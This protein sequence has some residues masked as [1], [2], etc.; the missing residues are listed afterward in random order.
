ASRL[1]AAA[2]ATNFGPRGM[3]LVAIKSTNTT[4]RRSWCMAGGPGTPW[5]L[6]SGRFNSIVV[7]WQSLAHAQDGGCGAWYD[8]FGSLGRAGRTHQRNQGLIVC[9]ANGVFRTAHHTQSWRGPRLSLR[10]W[11]SS[12]SLRTLCTGRTRWALWS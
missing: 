6:A 2:P 7:K 8:A 9:A 3:R 4:P 12:G 11:R 1:L 10:A 5:G